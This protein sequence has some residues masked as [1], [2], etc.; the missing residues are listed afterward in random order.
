MEAAH[1]SKTACRSLASSRL[2]CDST[3]FCR[4]WCFKT[5]MCSLTA[6][7]MSWLLAW[8]YCSNLVM[9]PVRTARAI[10]R[11]R[12][13]C[14]SRSALTS[15]ICSL[16][17]AKLMLDLRSPFLPS[18]LGIR[19]RACC[20]V[21]KMPNAA[22]RPA[23]ISFAS[24][25]PLPSV[26]NAAKVFWSSPN[27]LSDVLSS[28]PTKSNILSQASA[29]A[30]SFIL[31]ITRFQATRR[32][33]ATTCSSDHVESS[34]VVGASCFFVGNR[35]FRTLWFKR[36]RSSMDLMITVKTTKSEKPMNRSSFLSKS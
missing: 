23:V 9:A 33:A 7:S 12:S 15:S 32:W 35:R 28:W 20:W 5:T 19:P 11:N 1:S 21:T 4:A 30:S 36:H 3:S 29:A 8:A 13:L 31:L 27:L 18:T 22:S 26:S 6:V 14:L 17:S 10:Q 2:A 16:N 25:S 34:S 24:S